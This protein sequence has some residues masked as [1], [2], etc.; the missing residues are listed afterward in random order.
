MLHPY[1]ILI[2]LL[3]VYLPKYEEHASQSEEQGELASLQYQQ[4]YVQEGQYE[5]QYTKPHTCCKSNE[6]VC[7]TL[8][9]GQRWAIRNN[10]Y[11]RCK[12]PV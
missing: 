12:L 3:K 2:K 9:Y 5:T 10:L 7:S 11:K 6:S 8:K 4:W 1:F